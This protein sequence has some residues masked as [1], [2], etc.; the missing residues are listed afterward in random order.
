MPESV[1]NEVKACTYLMKDHVFG[2]SLDY[3][4]IRD[5]RFRTLNEHGSRVRLSSIPIAQTICTFGICSRYAIALKGLQELCQT[6]RPVAMKV[7][8]ILPCQICPH[9]VK[10]K[11]IDSNRNDE[12]A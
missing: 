8:Y 6:H 11:V 12:S 10:W 5:E 9:L 1:I 4:P 2:D 7:N 3:K